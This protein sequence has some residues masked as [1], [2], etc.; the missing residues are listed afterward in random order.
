MKLEKSKKRLERKWN[1][2]QCSI[3]E[4]EE[5]TMLRVAVTEAKV[6]R[7]CHLFHLTVLLLLIG[8]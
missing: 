8:I 6:T 1:D 4:M 5:L 3:E 2:N 7:Y